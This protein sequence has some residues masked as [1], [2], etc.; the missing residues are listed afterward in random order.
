VVKSP[1]LTDAAWNAILLASD[2]FLHRRGRK[3]GDGFEIDKVVGVGLD[4]YGL[5]WFAVHGRKLVERASAGDGLFAGEVERVWEPDWFYVQTAGEY[6]FANA[7]NEI[8]GEIS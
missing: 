7:V 5:A 1:N 3:V 8:S 4:P 6:G 2:Q